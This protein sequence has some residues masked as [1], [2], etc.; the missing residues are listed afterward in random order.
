[1]RRETI[2]TEFDKD[3]DVIKKR[4]V[5]DSLTIAIN[6]GK[7]ELEKIQKDKKEAEKELTSFTDSFFESKNSS[8][9]LFATLKNK[10]EKQ[11]ERVAE[12][13]KKISEITEKISKL[14]AEIN[15][16]ST[17]FTSRKEGVDRD[18]A[19]YEKEATKKS[20]ALA[21]SILEQEESVKTLEETNNSLKAEN[22][23][24]ISNINS[25]KEVVA[26][27]TKTLEE[28]EK[29][30][31]GLSVLIEAKTKEAISLSE[32]IT[33]KENTLKDINRNIESKD[34]VLRGLN[35]DIA[36]RQTE[37]TSL[38]KE[39]EDFER[40]K[41]TFSEQRT[42]ILAKEQFVKE[43]YEMAGLKYE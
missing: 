43:K 5:L 39:K 19:V 12:L 22:T 15:G 30:E 1:M 32:D 21:K 42:M 34:G 4:E 8:N 3:E 9:E 2:T 38:H 14:Q 27:A 41:L 31:K 28:A 36:F 6:E 10:E 26:K 24:L 33:E 29:K 18:V 25:N 17:S 7:K 11:K 23:G 16:L 13:S 40:E 20:K 37:L 35:R